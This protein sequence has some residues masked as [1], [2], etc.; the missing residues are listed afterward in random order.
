[1]KKVKPILKLTK[2]VATFDYPKE[3]IEGTKCFTKFIPLGES[4]GQ[5]YYNWVINKLGYGVPSNIYS[6]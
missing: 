6:H 1:M 2:I 3:G 4:G 5:T